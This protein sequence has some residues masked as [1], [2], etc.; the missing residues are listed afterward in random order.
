M[1][2]ILNLHKANPHLKGTFQLPLSKSVCN[3]ALLL[4]AF[5]PNLTLSGLSTS[6]DSQYLNNLLFESPASGKRLFVGAGGT[7]LRFALV[8]W[9]SQPGAHVVLEGT[10]KLNSRPIALLVEA[11][12]SLGAHI[13]YEGVDGAAPLI[14]YGKALK[15]GKLDL[16]HVP[17]SQFVTALMMLG[18][19]LPDR[20]ELTWSSVVSQPYLMMT[21]ALMRNAGLKVDLFTHGCTLYPAEG[22][23]TTELLIEP[24]WSSIA[25]WCQWVALSQSA[26]LFFPHFHEDSI[27]G[28]SKVLYYFE[29]LGVSH[30]FE[31]GGL[32]LAKKRVLAPGMMHY[33]LT[34]EPDLAQA[35]IT[36]LLVK[37]IPFE[38][39][40]LQ[41]LQHK[42]CDRIGALHYVAHTLG[43]HLD[44]SPV[45]VSCENYERELKAPKLPF[46]TYEDHRVAM[47]LAP[48]SLLFPVSI[49]NPDVV[50]KSYP[51]YWGHVQQLT[52]LGAE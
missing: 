32:R 26:D 9:A 52:G 20:L 19:T 42:E 1:H 45:S 51:E 30:S 41:T 44:C 31:E 46:P 3:R 34:G 22:I 25:F 39:N 23:P 37:R 43:V 5:Y 47:S 18:P 48:L 4:K 15:G 8:Y 10:P 50:G 24:D 28:D 11:L 17:S 36:T 38:V 21:A 40:G 14:I 2:E 16:G 33:N 12:R 7:T 6:E 49:L 27:Q 29:P 35:L 13:E